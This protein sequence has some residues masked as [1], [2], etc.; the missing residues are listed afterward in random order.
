M[1]AVTP[2][3]ERVSLDDIEAVIADAVTAFKAL[4]KD[5][6]R[7][8]FDLEADTTISSEYIILN[9]FLD[10]LEPEIEADL[11]AYVRK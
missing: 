6:G 2:S 8:E 5:D 11:A 7:F 4:Q 10:E 1:D 3:N 9:H